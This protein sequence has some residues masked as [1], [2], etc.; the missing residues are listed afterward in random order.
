MHPAYSV[1][2]FTTASG[3]GL[4]LLIW[5]CLFGFLGIVERSLGLGLAG[6]GIAL[7]L[8]TAGLLSS[9]FHLGRP[10]RAW[11]AFSQWRSSWLSREGV[12]AVATYAPAGLA[13]LGWLTGIGQSG[14]VQ[15]AE[16]LA[17]VG[18]IATLWCTGMIYASL[19]TIRAWN[20]PQ[21]PW[22]YLVLGLATGGLLLTALLY[23]FGQPAFEAGLVSLLA[24]AI[25]AI[26]KL[27]YWQAVDNLPPGLEPADATGLKSLGKVTVLDPPHTMDNFV[28]RE[29]GYAVGRKHADKLRRIVLIALFAV[30]IVGM[31][32]ALF[33]TAWVGAALAL[34]S[35]LLAAAGVVVERWLFFA[36][37]KH[38]VSLY[39]G[40]D[41]A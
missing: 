13:G 4:G 26:L 37:A 39:Y 40:A 34:I 31:L 28:M 10:E 2:F 19:T 9:T 22:I 16:L 8:T 5:L 41:A 30:P 27:R 15:V 25:G 23:L 38:V 6:F 21:V 3:A 14:A 36:Q 1:I 35:T 11:R 24:L 17:I 32:V 7:G 29:M 12:V 18:A 33:S 20:R